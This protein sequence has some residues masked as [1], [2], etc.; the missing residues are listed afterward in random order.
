[1]DR[2]LIEY[3]VQYPNTSIG[4]VAAMIEKATVAVERDLLIV[5][6]LVMILCLSDPELPQDPGRLENALDSV[7]KHIIWTLNSETPE[8]PKDF[9]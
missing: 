5:T 7:S 4:A 2:E 9:N 6:M 8:D 3:S 1:M